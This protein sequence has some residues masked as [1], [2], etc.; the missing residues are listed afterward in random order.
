[1][2][3]D[4]PRSLLNGLQMIV[5]MR[6]KT[7]HVPEVWAQ[8]AW[9]GGADLPIVLASRT[10]ICHSVADTDRRELHSLFEQLMA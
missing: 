7:H 4:A 6:Q 5:K 9:K 2:P 10:S 1:R 8:E 3:G